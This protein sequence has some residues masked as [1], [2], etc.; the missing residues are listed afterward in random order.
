MHEAAALRGAARDA[1]AARDG[2]APRRDRGARH[3]HLEGRL[4]GAAVRARG[5]RR[6]AGGAPGADP[7]RLPG[8]RRRQHPLA[9]HGL[10]RDRRDG[11]VRA[12]G[13]HRDPGRA[14]DGG[15]PG[16]PRHRQ[17]LRRAAAVLR[18][19]GRGRGRARRGRGA[20]RRPRARRLR[21]PG[22]RPRPRGA[23]RA[24]RQLRARPSQRPH[25]PARPDRPRPCG[26]HAPGDGGLDAA[27]QRP[28]LH[29]PL[30]PR[31]QRR[32]GVVPTPAGL[33]A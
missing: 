32:R 4:P 16:R 24:A 14:E 31:A 10:R 27:P 15:A 30:R 11:G 12:R 20:R 6:G 9:R 2:A 8:D 21:D 1:G 25:R 26:R 17:L 28:A 13:P 18:L 23:A 19:L 7:R 5:G 29:P 22:L 33:R 3:R